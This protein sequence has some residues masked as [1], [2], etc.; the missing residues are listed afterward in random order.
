MRLLHL[1]SCVTLDKYTNDR[2]NLILSSVT[3]QAFTKSHL[4]TQ[5]T[6]LG[7]VEGGEG[8]G[9]S[10]AGDRLGAKSHPA[11]LDGHVQGV[12]AIQEVHNLGLG[13]SDAIL[14]R[15][16]PLPALPV[17]FALHKHRVTWLWRPI[18]PA[19]MQSE[20]CIVIVMLM[21]SGLASC[22]LHVA[23]ECCLL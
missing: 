7:A 17:G 4:T 5:K 22:I 16:L 6:K 8:S 9:G 14:D 20:T 21:G 12:S 2:T 15:L 1:Q 18:P 13:Q 10:K 3:A 23:H 11:L 19:Q